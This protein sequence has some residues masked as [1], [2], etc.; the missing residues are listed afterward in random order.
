MSTK[1][2]KIYAEDSSKS[3]HETVHREE[4]D[5][6]MT[7]EE[8]I[9]EV[10]DVVNKPVTITPTEDGGKAAKITEPGLYAVVICN[11]IAATSYASFMISIC[12]LTKS[13][14]SYGVEGI[15]LGYIGARNLLYGYYPVE[16]ASEEADLV[17]V[18]QIVKY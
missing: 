10:N 5:E 14:F 2:P 8:F 7:Y 4:I 12:D 3:L 13:V 15:G 1:L 9:Q 16:G 17:S 18:K 6:A 11:A